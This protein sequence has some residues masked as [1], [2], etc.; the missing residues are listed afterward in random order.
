MQ[1]GIKLINYYSNE[2]RVTYV[3]IK[4]I[5][6]SYYILY[7]SNPNGM[8]KGLVFTDREKIVDV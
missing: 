7:E 6:Y 3:I 4:L 8:R 1:V 5:Q 2:M